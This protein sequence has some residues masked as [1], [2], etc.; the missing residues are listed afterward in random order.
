MPGARF[1]IGTEWHP[2]WSLIDSMEWLDP[3]FHR[4]IY[5]PRRRRYVTGSSL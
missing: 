5:A 2:A 1:V 4:G 3:E